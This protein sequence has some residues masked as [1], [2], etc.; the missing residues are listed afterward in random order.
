MNRNFNDK[1]HIR[2]LPGNVWA[3]SLTS[4][5]MD[6][7]SEMIHNILPLFLAN[8][9]GVRT[10]FIGLIEGIA[11]TISSLLRVFSGWFSDR[12]HH[13]K[14]LAVAGYGISAISRPFLY[15]ANSWG[16]VAGVRWTDRVGKGVR[17]APRDALV[18]DSVSASQRGLAFGFHRAADTAGASLGIGIALIT[19]LLTH[20]DI[21]RL[22]GSIFRIIV[23]ISLIPAFLSVLTLV[24]G[25]RDVTVSSREAY[26]MSGFSS[27]GRSFMLLMVIVGIFELGNSSDAFLILLAQE[28]G[29]S[30]NGILWMLLMY[31][32]VYAAVSTPAGSLSDRI[33]RRKMIISGWFIYSFIYLGFAFS[34]TSGHIFI[35]YAMYGIYYGMSYGTA[36]ALISDIVPALYRGTAY[37]IYNSVLGFLDLPASL[38][39]GILWQGIGP[40]TGLGPS[41]PFL[42][43][44]LLASLAAIL[45]CFWKPDEISNSIISPTGKT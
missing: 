5:F 33:E 15:V 28:R 24:I 32:I 31:N 9:L 39:A 3:L 6:V 16:V 44:A 36:K 13:R 42:F 7:S 8:V 1:R 45:M 2:T 23:L 34:K 29:V 4:F 20:G 12:L 18:A 14:W 40:W 17:T 38:V 41:A 25:A 37:G 19:I 21:S 22:T 35:L 10:V 43:G 26:S 27:M 30:V 11:E